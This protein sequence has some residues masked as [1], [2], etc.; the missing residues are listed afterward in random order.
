MSE[1]TQPVASESVAANATKETK[2]VTTPKRAAPDFDALVAEALAK[3]VPGIIASIVPSVVQAV[4]AAM[5][6]PV[7]VAT[8]ATPATVATAPAP[9]AVATPVATQPVQNQR[10]HGAGL[11]AKLE[12]RTT[13]R[14]APE[15][16]VRF[17]VGQTCH[18]PVAYKATREAI[19]ALGLVPG[20]R[21]DLKGF[22]SVNEGTGEHAGK[23][24]TKFVV[25][26]HKVLSRKA[27]RGP[28]APVVALGDATALDLADATDGAPA[29]A[30]TEVAVASEAPASDAMQ[31][32]LAQLPPLESA[33]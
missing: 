7:A 19:L 2:K 32:L 4:V 28:A 27:D 29:P 6:P 17:F 33:F 22:I 15:L 5:T 12:D 14:G 24:F 1:S 30:A 13:K 3:Q 23:T 18:Y 10:W 9:A 26:E 8:P 25:T 21:I 11:L 20:D 31:S 16:V